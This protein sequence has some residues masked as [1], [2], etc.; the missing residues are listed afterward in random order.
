[1]DGM[2]G[3]KMGNKDNE[4]LSGRKGEE[5]F[6]WELMLMPQKD[7]KINTCNTRKASIWGFI[8][9]TDFNSEWR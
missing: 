4:Y 7:I 5:E 8:L 9:L 3:R 6:S 1:M 2:Q